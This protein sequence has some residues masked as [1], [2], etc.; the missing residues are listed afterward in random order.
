MK[1]TEEVMLMGYG[2]SDSSGAWIKLQVKPEDLDNFRGLKGQRFACALQEF[3]EGT[4][5]LKEE[6][7]VRH[8]VS[9]WLGIR[10]AEPV[11]QEF[12][13]VSNTEEAAQ[14]VRDICGVKSRSEIEASP[15]AM[16]QFNK[17]RMKY[18]NHLE[19]T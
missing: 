17:L 5:E 11:F 16:I 1:F 19:G 3:V 13:G 7:K 4:D 9:Q 10:C 6:P 12:L 15:E 18:S 14:K 2:E 8:P